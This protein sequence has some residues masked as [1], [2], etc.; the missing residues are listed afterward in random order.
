MVL[1][2][3][4]GDVLILEG[5]GLKTKMGVQGNF[6]ERTRQENKGEEKKVMEKYM[7]DKMGKM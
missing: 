7:N 4:E 5:Y 6:G 3:A 1:S 2:V